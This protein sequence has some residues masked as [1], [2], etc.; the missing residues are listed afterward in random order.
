MMTVLRRP[1]WSRAVVSSRTPVREILSNRALSPEIGLT[2]RIHGTSC[3]WRRGDT[4]RSSSGTNGVLFGLSA[5][6]GMLPLGQRQYRRGK[7]EARSLE[8]QH[9]VEDAGVIAVRASE[10]PTWQAGPERVL[11]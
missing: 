5:V 2:S 9:T 6:G 3:G 10:S 4:R 7:S 1:G 8:R 11:Y